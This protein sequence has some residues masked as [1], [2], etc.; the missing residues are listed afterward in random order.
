MRIGVIGTGY[1]GLVTGTCFAELGNNVIC[2]DQD[3]N[4]VDT[5]RSG[6]SP[7][8][9]P[10]L[11]DLLTH[12]IQSNRL[13]FTTDKALLAECE[14]VFLA[15]NTPMA[16][17]GRANLTYLLNALEESLPH[18]Q[19][20]SLL[21]VKSTVPVGTSERC[22]E[23]IA[24]KTN[25]KIHV[26]SN[27]EFLKEGAAINDFMRPDRIIVGTRTE[28]AA[29]KMNDL[30]R[31]FLRQGNPL[32]QMTNESSELSKY[33]C[34]VFLAT[35]IAFINEV[36][37]LCD[38]TGAD[39]EQ[40]RKAMGSDPRIGKPF[41]YPGPG[42]GGSCFPKDVAALDHMAKTSETQMMIPSCTIESNKRQ[43][44][45][46]AEKLLRYFENNLDGKTIAIW[47]LTF[48]AN[49]DDV[50]D[51][52]SFDSVQFLQKYNCNIRLF[53]P[54]G[55]DNF[56]RVMEE[57]NSNFDGVE[58][59]ANKYDCLQNADALLVLTEWR[60]FQHPD[61]SIMIKEMKSPFIF[62]GRNLYEGQKVQE[63]GFKY[64]AIG[65]S[66]TSFR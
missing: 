65:K 3:A 2:V 24:K 43:K 12:N 41:L 11:S 27:P 51:S 30:Y 17:D 22:E 62:D 39:I 54:M 18:L 60:E 35:K 58:F 66:D 55:N 42:F 59:F 64:M 28:E 1:V 63:L 48:K 4:K 6:N 29:N 34:N 50:R 7:I 31:P 26:V 13:S 45:F 25:K 44:T 52:A 8:Y 16:D 37:R 33:A 9:E 46:L 53:D 40:V 32:F 20:N 61:F 49:T 23:I 47:G 10:G 38:K 15:V 19:E 5:L 14:I 21:V 36:S 57:K 56:K